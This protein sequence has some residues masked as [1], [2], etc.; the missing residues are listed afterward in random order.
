MKRNDNRRTEPSSNSQKRAEDISQCNDN[1]LDETQLD[2]GK[3]F[4]EDFHVK[5][6][7][8]QG[9]FGRIYLVQRKLDGELFAAK[10]FRTDWEGSKFKEHLFFQE[11]RTWIDLSPHPNMTACRFFRTYE[12]T[13]VIFAEY[14]DGGSLG[15]WIAT[16]KNRTIEN[17]LDIAIQSAWG[18]HAAHIQGV[19]HQ[20]VK[21]ENIL[22]TNDRIAKVTDFG[23]ARK[24]YFSVVDSIMSA[25]VSSSQADNS[26]M[27]VAYCSPE[28]AMQ[29]KVTKQTDIWS[30]GIMVFEMF[31]G[32][33]TWRIGSVIPQAFDIYVK[34]KDGSYQ[35]VMPDSVVDVLRGC[36]Q[37]NPKDRWESFEEITEVLQTI[38]L[39]ES[40]KKY[41][42]QEVKV[43]KP[44]RVRK[45]IYPKI[46]ETENKLISN[47][48]ISPEEY[49]TKCG[50]FDFSNK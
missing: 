32:E 20:D 14:V 37:I 33:V 29:E 25:T 24:R 27:T 8:G 48:L 44:R 40:G 49:W 17:I 22:M 45:T 3:A 9:G 16:E 13:L 43:K 47:R 7:L 34:M 36:F 38:Y 46:S 31:I 2:I 39:E 50:P 21:P 12:N 10:I 11:L 28:Q 5:K 23:A 6:M 1:I 26:T 30:W 42:R 41:P 19:I 18:L 35:P 4:R 15:E